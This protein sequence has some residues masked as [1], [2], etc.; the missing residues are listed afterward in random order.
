MVIKGT[1]DIKKLKL[2]LDDVLSR[3]EVFGCCAARTQAEEIF[4]Q[5]PELQKEYKSLIK[6]YKLNLN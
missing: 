1:E 6:E 3:I 4:K 2:N 5:H